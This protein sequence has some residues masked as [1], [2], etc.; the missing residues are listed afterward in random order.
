M[1]YVKIPAPGL[2]NRKGERIIVKLKTKDLLGTQP[3]MGVPQP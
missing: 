2:L 3:I 1:E